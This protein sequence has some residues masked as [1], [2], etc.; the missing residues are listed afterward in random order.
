MNP[1]RLSLALVALLLVAFTIFNI[2]SPG[3]RGIVLYSPHDVEVLELVNDLA[4]AGVPTTI[5]PKRLLSAQEPW[6][7]IVLTPSVVPSIDKR[8]LGFMYADGAML[9]GLNVHASELQMLVFGSASSG[10]RAPYDIIFSMVHDDV[11]PGG[12]GS[13]GSF[14]DGAQNYTVVRTVLHSAREVASVRN[15]CK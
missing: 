11:R 2:P 4:Q 15:S 13:T 9:V 12:C 8:A 6:Q 5:N 10:M 7:F 14:E 3:T 1:L